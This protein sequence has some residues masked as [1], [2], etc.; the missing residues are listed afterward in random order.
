MEENV[1]INDIENYLN[2]D[3]DK[4]LE[5]QKIIQDIDNEQN[6][7]AKYLQGR[8]YNF[9]I[10]RFRNVGLTTGIAKYFNEIDKNEKDKRVILVS[11]KINTT[12]EL[13]NIMKTNMLQNGTVFNSNNSNSII[14]KNNN[15]FFVSSIKALSNKVDNDPDKGTKV[16]IDNANSIKPENLINILDICRKYSYDV[17]GTINLNLTKSYNEIFD[18]INDYKISLVPYPSMNGNSF[19]EINLNMNE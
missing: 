14:T 1:K 13:F 16:Y 5:F 11:N 2:E 9:V 19:H 18:I 7:L 15:H 8:K 6:E 3:S 10:Q 12:V 17:K 4:Y